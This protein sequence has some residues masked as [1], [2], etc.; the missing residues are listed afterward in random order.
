[1]VPAATLHAALYQSLADEPSVIWFAPAEA[2]DLVLNEDAAEVRLRDQRMIRAALCIAADG[3]QSKLRDAAGIK[4]VGWAYGQAGI[5]A[6]VQ[7]GEPHRGVAIQH[8]LPGGP[9]AILPLRDNRACITW[10]AESAGSD[11]GHGAR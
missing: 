11:A 10:S 9:F 4:T 6:T 2:E 5:V 3:R 1:M 8:F 7:F